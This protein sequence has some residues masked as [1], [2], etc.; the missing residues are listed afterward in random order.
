MSRSCL[1]PQGPCLKHNSY[2]R[3]LGPPATALWGQARGLPLRAAARTGLSGPMLPV[4]FGSSG[5]SVSMPP[6]PA[7]QR[8]RFS[9]IFGNTILRPSSGFGYPAAGQPVSLTKLV[10]TGRR[11]LQ[12]PRMFQGRVGV[13]WAGLT[14]TATSSFSVAGA[15]VLALRRVPDSS[16]TFGNTT[17]AADSGPCGKAPAESISRVDI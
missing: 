9:T 3:T 8:G 11:P 7:R 1:A 4:T 15:T 6:V 10:P 17:T 13:R 14:P 5:D 12:R 2:V 16:M